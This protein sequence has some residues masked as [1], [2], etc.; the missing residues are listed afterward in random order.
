MATF[1]PAVISGGHVAN[2]SNGDNLSIGTGSVA[3]GQVNLNAGPTW[4]AGAGSPVSSCTAGSTYSNTAGGSTTTLYMCT[5]TNT[6]T[7]VQPVI[8]GSLAIINA[9]QAG[10]VNLST[11]GTGQID[12]LF[13]SSLAAGGPGSPRNYDSITSDIEEKLTGGG[14][15]LSPGVDALGNLGTLGQANGGNTFSSTAADT[16]KN[17]ALSSAQ[18]T[19]LL[20]AGV[21]SGFRFVAPATTSTRVLRIYDSH[22]SATMVCTAHM[23]DNSA[24]DQTIT[25][26][27]G[28]STNV[29]ELQTVT[30]RAANP[31]AYVIVNC[32]FTAIG[33]GTPNMRWYAE[34]L[35]DS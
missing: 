12:W 3:A 8:A 13:Q 2:L 21:G 32:Q 34:V 9:T 7:A 15:L 30:F 14:V 18:G 31:Q 28:S 29:Q 10:A 22:F 20:T 17:A 6:W 19:Q 35:S 23:S 1:P 27:S 24:A 26:N 4:T 33:A 11:V 5:A 16:L 25:S